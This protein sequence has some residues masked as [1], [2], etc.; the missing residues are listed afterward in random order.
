MWKNGARGA[1]RAVRSCDFKAE[2]RKVGKGE[3]RPRAM[4]AEN[5]RVEEGRTEAEKMRPSESAA[6]R[7]KNS[8]TVCRRVG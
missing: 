7:R 8:S 3:R 6:M 2:K 5:V 4:R 1:W